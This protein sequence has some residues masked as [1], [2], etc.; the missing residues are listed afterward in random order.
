MTY[1]E[2][3]VNTNDLRTNLLHELVGARQ[4]QA[5]IF[6]DSEFDALLVRFIVSDNSAYVHY[7]DG[8]VA[9]LVFDD[10]LEVFG[11]QIENFER[12]VVPKYNELKAVWGLYRTQPESS[13]AQQSL[14]SGLHSVVKGELQ[15]S[16][17]EKSQVVN[18][19]LAVLSL[20]PIS[21]V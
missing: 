4:F 10:G 11:L 6:Y 19:M 17:S 13:F 16:E 3:L 2:P 21:T 8:E 9:L 5:S 14:V 7:L 20:W 15:G 18:E 12:K 1:L